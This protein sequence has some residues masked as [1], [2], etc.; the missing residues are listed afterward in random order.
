MEIVVAEGVEGVHLTV[1]GDGAD[2][3]SLVP[4][5]ELPARVR[6]L[7][8]T[9][10]PRWVWA[11]TAATYTRPLR[12]GVRVERCYDLRLCRTIL[13]RAVD[14]P[15]PSDLWD[16]TE[17]PEERPD[18]PPTLFESVP[19]PAEEVLAE[20]L[21]QRD[22]VA[23]SRNPGRLATLLAA[24]SAGALLAAEMRHDGL[25]WSR[26]AHDRL[27]AEVLG[28]RPRHGGRPAVLEA[29]AEDVRR[30][31]GAPK[32]NPDSGPALLRA[33]H[34]AGITAQTTR[35]W[36]LEQIDHPSIAPLLEYK[37]LARLH[38][39]NGWAW[40]D[41]WV[42]PGP[43]G[44]RERFH[45]DYVPG[46]VVTGRWATRGGGALQ[47]PKQV[48]GAVV[49]DPG[50]TLVVADVAQLEPRVLAAMARDEAMARA[51]RGQD[52]Y[53]GL[54]DQGVIDT[55]AHA[56]VAMLGALYGATTG[57]SGE[58]VPRLLRAFPRA[59]SVV[60]GAAMR[61]EV[62]NVVRTWLG[63]T[64]PQPP[65]AWKA[66]QDRQHEPEATGE[67]RRVARRLARDWGRFTRNF[68]VQGTAAE[69]SLCWLADLRH[70]LRALSPDDGAARGP[71]LVFFLHD[72]VIVHTPAELADDVAAA[73]RESASGA[74]RLLFGDFPVDFPLDV[75][76]VDTYADA[77]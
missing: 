40:A 17:E 67:D 11:D 10:R 66:A 48:R 34:S 51:A 73:V 25:P 39:A 65:A 1:L 14:A 27:L 36:E 15:P 42:R 31:L 47:L 54:V 4:V 50:W 62:G 68:V 16:G 58:L 75:H 30:A 49:A 19:L 33:L 64:S 29:L 59:T 22:A 46:G 57:R 72:E 23:A 61:G 2:A 76:I 8:G 5:A 70:R 32:L 3:T 13:R 18:A 43:P 12:A 37:K 24:E 44:S 45:P 55:R 71:H 7:E 38:S 26:E 53:Q 35:K 60:E 77:D 56:K 41:E 74:G 52:L 63:R 21:R 20:R 6:A 28:P 9:H 69:W